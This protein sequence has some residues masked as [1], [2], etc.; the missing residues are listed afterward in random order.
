MP[1]RKK[2]DH[3]WEFIEK[4]IDN[5]GHQIREFYCKN[6]TAIVMVSDDGREDII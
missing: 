6:C 3:I 5:E 2:C 4:W 1:K